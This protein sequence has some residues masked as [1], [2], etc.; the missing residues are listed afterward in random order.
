MI[1]SNWTSCTRAFWQLLFGI[2]TYIVSIALPF[3][4]RLTEMSIT[5]A[6]P[7]SYTATK[8]AFELNEVFSMLW[9]IFNRNIATFG[10]NK[11]LGLERSTCVLCLVHCCHTILSSSKVSPFTLEAHKVSI[12]NHWI[13]FRFTKVNWRFIS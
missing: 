8:L 1:A 9:A 7:L 5:P 12:D 6:E 11:L 13:V 4:A 10:A 2:L 3:M